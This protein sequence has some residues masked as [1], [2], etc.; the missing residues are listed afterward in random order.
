MP[1]STS[2]HPLDL[3]GNNDSGNNDDKNSNYH[4]PANER[5]VS[6]GC[7]VRIAPLWGCQGRYV[8]IAKMLG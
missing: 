2:T 6:N 3:P 1:V 8:L 5:L 4:V 7:N